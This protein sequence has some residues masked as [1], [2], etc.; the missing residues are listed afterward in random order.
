MHRH[1]KKP[2][3]KANR[4]VAQSRPDKKRSFDSGSQF[5]DSRPELDLRRIHK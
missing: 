2:I 5:A 4:G 3:G 1:V